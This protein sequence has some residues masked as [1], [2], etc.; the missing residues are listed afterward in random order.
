MKRIK[1]KWGGG[2]QQKNVGAQP[3]ADDRCGCL[4]GPHSA[5][6][7]QG[8]VVS[9]LFLQ[10]LTSFLDQ[11]LPAFVV[12]ENLDAVPPALRTPPCGPLGRLPPRHP[13]R[14]TG[15]PPCPAP[16]PSCRSIA[17]DWHE[18]HSTHEMVAQFMPG[19]PDAGLPGLGLGCEP[20]EAVETEGRLRLM[21]EMNADLWEALRLQHAGM[22]GGGAPCESAPTD[23]RT[24][25]PR[26]C[27]SVPF[28]SAAHNPP[29]PC[30]SPTAEARRDDPTAAVRCT[31]FQHQT[32]AV[33]VGMFTVRLGSRWGPPFG[34]GVP[35]PPLHLFS[36]ASRPPSNSGRCGRNVGRALTE[37]SFHC[38]L[39]CMDA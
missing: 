4:R 34:G 24:A 37:V 21:Q 27:K 23:A 2:W 30:R 17:E 39:C 12:P 18:A 16:V 3:P 6:L 19:T 11:A 35:G 20:L 36:F 38:V 14:R 29:P 5:F 1:K 26:N 22:W 33:V 32:S 25:L 8:C 9:T 7:R 15:S 28:S 31:A 10:F 13:R